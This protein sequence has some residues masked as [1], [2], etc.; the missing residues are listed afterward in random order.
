MFCGVMS[1]A[2]ERFFLTHE[3][4][5]R[6]RAPDSSVRHWMRTGLLPSFKVG[7][8]RLVRESDLERFLLERRHKAG[9]A[10]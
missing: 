6:L 2:A 4:A 8:R 5:K 3:I 7:K 1:K 10:E 9:S